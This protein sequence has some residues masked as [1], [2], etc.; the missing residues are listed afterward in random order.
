[1]R[2]SNYGITEKRKGREYIVRPYIGKDP[3][4]GRYIRAK[5][6]TVHGTL[7][8]ARAVRDSI[9]ERAE[10]GAPS[11]C[12]GMTFGAFARQWAETRRACGEVSANT[13]GKDAAHIR[14]L[15][16]Y[17]GGMRLA[18]ITPAVVESTLTAI[19]ADKERERG[20]YSNTTLRMLYCTLSAVLAKAAAFG[21]IPA[22]PCERVKPPR[23]ASPERR[24]LSADQARALLCE[25]ER[26]EAASM[27]AFIGKENR[28]TERGNCWGR[29]DLRGFGA[30]AN[31]EA[32]RIAL[33]TG[34]RRGE[35][36][37]LTWSAIDL[38]AR[39]LE[40]RQT[41][42]AGGELKR[43]KTAAGVRRVSLDAATADAL[44]EWRRFQSKQFG[45]L[46]AVLCGD[47]PVI[48]ND[49]GGFHDL[50]A[51]SRWWHGWR[52]SAGFPGLRFHELRHT[53]ATLLLA[54]GVDVKTVQTRM[55]HAN[56]A[57]TL[58]WY[59]HAVPANDAAAADVFGA[60]TAPKQA[61][62]LALASAETAVSRA[63]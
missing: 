49:A 11:D 54:A 6:V 47:S 7:N 43:P 19:K 8:E 41:L 17:I 45:K 53:Q 10:R 60:I 59:A 27:D 42:T 12:E 22:N 31:H 52:A 23:N 35:V 46:G 18:D 39:T 33:A 61:R 32:V 38:D 51:A 1:M 44:K 15:S 63:V 55:G 9:V 21:Y 37:G 58:N 13:Q 3:V 34:L 30:I 2:G 20:G 4:T 28:Q 56:A 62:L 57:I 24:A 14:L 25:L 36:Y 29:S 5:A 50:R 48:C 16:A 26:S 40:V